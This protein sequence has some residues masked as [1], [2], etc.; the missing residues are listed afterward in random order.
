[1]D[2]PAR[3]RVY[4]RMPPSDPLMDDRELDSRRSTGAVYWEGAVRI[5]P[6][7]SGGG[8]GYLELTGYADALKL[9]KD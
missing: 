3:Q 4:P 1:M 8:P 6:R 7:W 9:G 5:A 2:A